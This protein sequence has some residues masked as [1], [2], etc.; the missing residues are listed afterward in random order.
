VL[1][2]AAV[3]PI[4]DP[5]GLFARS[6]LAV[7][8]IDGP[9]KLEKEAA[10]GLEFAGDL[11]AEGKGGSTHAPVLVLEETAHGKMIADELRPLRGRTIGCELCVQP[12]T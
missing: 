7:K 1:W 11:F 6:A 8:Q 5:R 9:I 12:R 10:K 3:E 2:F 4:G